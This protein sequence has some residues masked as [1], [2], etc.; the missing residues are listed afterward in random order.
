[1]SLSLSCKK[2]TTTIPTNYWDFRVTYNI[3]RFIHAAVIHIPSTRRNH[4]V[5][6]IT[7]VAHK[8]V[9]IPPEIV[10]TFTAFATHD[11]VRVRWEHV[12]HGGEVG[13]PVAGGTPC[14]RS[15][16]AGTGGDGDMRGVG[17]V[18]NITR[19]AVGERCSGVAHAGEG[20]PCDESF[21]GNSDHGVGDDAGGRIGGRGVRAG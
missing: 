18:E 15:V 19:V 3:N 11:A 2:T 12:G 7:S 1:M 14:A 4:S 16:V 13:G 17:G 10:V 9:A 8:T 6:I 20:G 5:T 21:T